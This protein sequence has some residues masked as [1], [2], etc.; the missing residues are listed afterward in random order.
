MAGETYA[1]LT[2]T[3][4]SLN[5]AG[6]EG[7][8]FLMSSRLDTSSLTGSTFTPSPTSL[9]MPA[10][11]SFSV[12]IR[13]AVKMSLRLFGDVLANSCAVLLP[14]PDEAPVIKIVFPSSRL[15]CAV[16]IVRRKCGGAGRM[17]AGMRLCTN[18]GILGLETARRKTGIWETRKDSIRALRRNLYGVPVLINYAMGTVWVMWRVL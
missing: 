12:S 13:L 18:L 9:L 3:S 14:M 10:A 6:K 11:T 4:I 1:L 8:K 15:P 2:S 17:R 7:M 5:S 16:A